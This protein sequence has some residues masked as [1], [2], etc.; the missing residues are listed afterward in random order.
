MLAF[1]HISK[2]AGTTITQVLRNSF[3]PRHCDVR[4]WPYEQ[5][6][7]RVASAKDLQRLSLVYW[8][9]ASIAGHKIVAY[10]DLQDACSD[11]RIFTFCREPLARMASHYQSLVKKRPMADDFFKWIK[12]GEFWNWQTQTLA[13]CQDAEMAIEILSKKI[14]FVGLTEHFNESLLMFRR[15][16]G[17][18][19]IDIHYS[20]F[21]VAT[22]S[23]IKHRLLTDPASRAALMDANREDLKLY[24]FVVQELYPQQQTSYG[25]ELGFDVIRFEQSNDQ[26]DLA[27]PLL[28]KLVRNWIYKPLMPLL[29]RGHVPKQPALRRSA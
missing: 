10:S 9:L 19:E 11:L 8:R 4:L 22:D 5:H 20:S 18:E 23:S 29:T 14:G 27:N 7:D 24:N 15:W 1:V 17:L 2:T 21:N 28:G 3:G 25:P 13:G 6:S 16:C 26:S 12:S